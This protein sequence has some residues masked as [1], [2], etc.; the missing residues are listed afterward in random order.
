[1]HVTKVRVQ[2]RPVSAAFFHLKGDTQP[3]HNFL[4]HTLSVYGQDLAQRAVER[5]ST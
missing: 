4:N 3:E 5:A 2:Q 1:M